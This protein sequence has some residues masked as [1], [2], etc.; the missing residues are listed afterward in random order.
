MD[1]ELTPRLVTGRI[2]DI[3][4]TSVK[5]EL[6]GKMGMINL[7]LRCVFADKTLKPDDR[8]KIYISYAQVLSEEKQEEIS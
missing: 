5:I 8:V 1:I 2:V 7:P 3:T 6:K 4:E